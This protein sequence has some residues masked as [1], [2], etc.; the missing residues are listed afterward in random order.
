MGIKIGNMRVSGLIAGVIL[1]VLGALMMADSVVTLSGNTA[2]L[3][4]ENMNRGFEF[5]VG[6]MAIVLGAVIMDL[7]RA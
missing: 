6:L 3:F 5:V 4:V 2:F 1:V 7:S